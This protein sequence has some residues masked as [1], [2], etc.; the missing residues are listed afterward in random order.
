MR[1]DRIG[2]S[3]EFEVCLYLRPRH[4]LPSFPFPFFLGGSILFNVFLIF[5]LFQERE[6]F[7]GD[8]RGNGF[9]PAMDLHAF[10]LRHDA[11][12]GVRDG[13]VLFLRDRVWH[14]AIVGTPRRHEKRF[15]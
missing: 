3:L 4:S 8:E 14:G 11:G 15:G 10:S 12:E 9:S 13:A 2:T 5:Q 7:Q 1:V 6:V